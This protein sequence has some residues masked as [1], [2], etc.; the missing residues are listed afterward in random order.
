MMNNFY[1]TTPIY[2]VNDIPH[3]GH[4]YSTIAC[5]ILARFNKL[6]NKNVFFLTGTD[7]H[8]QKVEKAAQ[9][10]NQDPQ[11]FVDTISQSFKNLIPA[12]GCEINDFIR[13]TESR[14]KVAAQALWKKLEENNQ[15]YLSNYEGWYSI[16]DETFYLEADL[17]KQDDKS[18][19]APTGAEVEWVKEKSYFFK[20]S[21]WQDKLISFYEKNPDS[22][23]PKSRYNEVLSF[24]NGG[25]KDL[26]ISRTTFKWGIPVPN[27]N[28]HV[29]YVW[30]DALCNY[31]SALGYPD[32]NSENFK[33]FWPGVHI[34]GKDILRFHTV[35]W[36]AF[37][38][39]ADLE[40]PK[41]VFAHGW[42]TNEGQKISKSLGNAIDP[43]EIISKFGIDQFRFYL[44]REV[45]FG[46]DGDFSIKSI[47]QRVNSD[48]SNNFGNLVQRI[49]S[50]IAKNCN[51]IVENNFDLIDEDK[52]ILNL[53]IK[54]IQNYQNYL[55]N[56]EIDKALKEIF[57]LLS[58]TN[59]YIDKQAPWALKKTDVNRMN[60]V[61]SLSIELI[62][63]SAFMLSPVIPFGCEKIFKI[64]NIDFSKL[65]FD[66]ICVMNNTK[67]KINIP[68]AV[69]P[70]IENND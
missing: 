68:I 9:L 57:E 64:L 17:I 6:Q 54:K 38:M 24:I 30:I 14:H 60:V 56:Q 31:I 62:K 40:P 18:Y 5:D 66:N 53:S 29:L 27:N 69:F 1:I 34:V 63:R 32:V 7:E 39:A 58:E 16:R 23:K 12:L 15:I 26:S 67:H 50:F 33:K 22:I 47:A 28:D 21:D 3:V 70:R 61:L 35:Y 51:H 13:T 43:Y 4:A 52:K 55:N 37:L 25:L 65:S 8:G 48:L 41:R 11:N 2:Y 44:F 20:L 59:V 45:P 49:C 42:W 19:L 10:R 36:P 46:N